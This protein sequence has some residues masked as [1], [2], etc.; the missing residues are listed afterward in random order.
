MPRS[1]SFPSGHAASAFAFASGVATAAP[2]VGMLLTP[3]AALV[4]YS[5][6]HTGVHYPVDVI[7]GTVT[8]V[9][10]APMTVA[11]LDRRRARRRRA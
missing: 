9:A 8:G 5:R 7:A 10:M 1:T 4:G 6:I 3:L 11:A 2:E